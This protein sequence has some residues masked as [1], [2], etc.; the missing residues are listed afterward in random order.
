M[1]LSAFGNEI[2]LML[3]RLGHT[4]ITPRPDLVTTKAGRNTSPLALTLSTSADQ[5]PGDRPPSHRHC[6][7]QR[8][9]RILRHPAQLHARRRALRGHHAMISIVDGELLN[10]S[11]QRSLRGVTMPQTYRAMCCQCG[12]IIQHRLDKGHALPCGN[13]ILS[14]RRLRGLRLS[15]H[16]RRRQQQ[17]QATPNRS[18]RRR[19]KIRSMHPKAQIKRRMRAHNAQAARARGSSTTAAKLFPA[20][21][22]PAPRGELRKVLCRRA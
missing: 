13:G 14:R 3:E 4:I 5:I 7:S 16:A 18:T 1:T 19:H 20:S 17:A 15:N 22:R 8:S 21:R 10:R 9:G 2:A 6:Q 11:M 12:E